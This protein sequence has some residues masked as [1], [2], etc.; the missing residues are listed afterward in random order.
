MQFLADLLQV[1]TIR[2]KHLGRV[3]TLMLLAEAFFGN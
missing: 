3:Y 1:S 2:H